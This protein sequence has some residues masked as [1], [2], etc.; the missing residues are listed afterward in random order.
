MKNRNLLT[1]TGLVII[2]M[3]MFFAMAL[4]RADAQ[5]SD[6]TGLPELELFRGD[7]GAGIPEEVQYI[8]DSST[9]PVVI[10][11]IKYNGNSFD[12]AVVATAAD[13]QA[14]VE[15]GYVTW[16]DVNGVHDET[17]IEEFGEVFGLSPS[18]QQDIANTTRLPHM[19]DS[20]DYIF[21]SLEMLNKDFAID[22]AKLE[23]ISL[24]LGKDYVISFQESDDNDFSSVYDRLVEKRGNIP[25]KG[26]DYLGFALVDTIVDSYFPAID[27]M[28]EQVN[29]IE[30]KLID[31]PNEE[32][33]ESIYTIKREVTIGRQIIIPMREII[34]SLA[35]YDYPLI[36]PE[37][38]DY[39]GITY[40]NVDYLGN[41]I[42]TFSNITSDMVNFYISIY[43]H[44]T[45]NL[46]K[47]LTIF[48]TI[49]FVLSFVAAVYGTDFSQ[50]HADEKRKRGHVIIVF[51]MIGLA[52]LLVMY[53]ALAGWL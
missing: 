14:F 30:K 19:E 43:G 29:V 39:Y 7:D 44:D 33:L 45:N 27:A 37:I 22:A 32:L 38:K 40:E 16:I 36:S 46:L 26:S 51:V 18:V 17:V 13:A 52:V 15:E 35:N 9:E 20:N 42:E 2:V 24:V 31:S 12:E 11:V 28:N 50:F 4:P 23:Q 1:L 21:L 8:G 47:F 10:K 3:A 49:L 41:I 6:P 25:E 5:T 53:F 34:Y 48:T